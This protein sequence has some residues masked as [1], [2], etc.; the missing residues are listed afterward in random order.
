MSD[1]AWRLSQAVLIS[2]IALV[3]AKS[4]LTRSDKRAWRRRHRCY[5]P[6]LVAG[7]CRIAALRVCRT[8]RCIVEGFSSTENRVLRHPVEDAAIPTRPARSRN[9]MVGQ[10][11]KGCAL[12]TGPANDE[13]ARSDRPSRCGW[14]AGCKAATREYGRGAFARF[15]TIDSLRRAILD[16]YGGR[17]NAKARAPDTAATS[18]SL[19]QMAVS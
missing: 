12:C 16:R 1:A 14:S 15:I 7:R 10:S 11:L 13:M 17:S 2:D 9:A 5:A 6:S 18:G 4:E 8:A 3:N 19:L